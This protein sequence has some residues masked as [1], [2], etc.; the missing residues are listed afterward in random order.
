MVHDL[1]CRVIDLKIG[2]GGKPQSDEVVLYN[3]G[4]K[5]G[6]NHREA[7]RATSASQN[8]A[9]GASK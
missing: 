1:K 8:L 3:K 5:E 4:D 9:N 6:P 2:F 7:A